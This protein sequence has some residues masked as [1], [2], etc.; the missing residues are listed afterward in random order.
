MFDLGDAAVLGGLLPG[1]G[2]A[3]CVLEQM[4][5]AHG[6]HYQ[7]ELPQQRRGWRRG[8]RNRH[9][10]SSSRGPGAAGPWRRW[11]CGW[12]RSSCG[13]PCWPRPWCVLGER[14]GG[15]ERRMGECVTGK[16]CRPVGGSASWLDGGSGSGAGE[17]SSC[18]VVDSCG[19]GRSVQPGGVACTCTC[20]PG[21]EV[22]LGDLH[23]V[24]G[25]HWLLC[26]RGRILSALR[27]SPTPAVEFAAYVLV[28]I[29]QMQLTSQIDVWAGE[30][31]FHHSRED[32]ADTSDGSGSAPRCGSFLMHLEDLLAVLLWTS[33][34]VLS[35]SAHGGALL[36]WLLARVRRPRSSSAILHCVSNRG[37]RLPWADL[38]LLLCK[39]YLPWRTWP[40]TQPLEGLYHFVVWANV[41]LA[42]LGLVAML[43]SLVPSSRCLRLG[44]ADYTVGGTDGTD[45]GGGSDGT[46]GGGGAGARYW[47]LSRAASTPHGAARTAPLPPTPGGGARRKSSMGA[48]IAAPLVAWNA[49][50][51]SSLGTTRVDTT[52]TMTPAAA[53]QRGKA[54]LSSSSRGPPR[55]RATTHA[56]STATRG[57][58]EPSRVTRDEPDI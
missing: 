31:D 15:G 9:A 24:Q 53:P 19:G 47:L 39:G 3:V 57:S 21:W 17:R 42:V 6:R 43:A 44:T 13:G 5:T 29:V 8:Q 45:G 36:A 58:R 23:A 26:E 27:V 50:R 16:P 34:L 33:L 55:S 2:P 20:T 28:S 52:T 4:I 10:A 41:A 12:V 35:T 40:E 54:P 22:R 56:G 46:S 49:R 7:N 1:R 48:R 11:C 14:I 37:A 30:R 25:S 18:R 38:A 32:C 51:G